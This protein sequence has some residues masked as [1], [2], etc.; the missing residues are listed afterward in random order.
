M[1]P[2]PASLKGA[3]ISTCPIAVERKCACR[4][5]DEPLASEFEVKEMMLGFRKTFLYSECPG[6]GCL[7]LLDPPGDMGAY[8][9]NNYYAFS[10]PTK[11]SR[12][13]MQ[14]AKTSLRHF[15]L[16]S[17]IPGVFAFMERHG[18]VTQAERWLNLGRARR[19][20]RILDIGCGSG[21]LLRELQADGYRNLTGIDPFSPSA[22]HIPGLRLIKGELEAL[23]GEAFDLV[24]MHHSLEHVPDQ[25][26]MLSA[27]RS[28]LTPKGLLLVRIPIKATAFEIYGADWVQID[29]P[30]H[31]L[32]HS[33]RSLALAA[34]RA[35][36]RLVSKVYDSWSFQFWG[37]EQYRLGIHLEDPRSVGKGGNAFSP[38]AI[39]EYNRRAGVLNT[40]QKGD[41]GIFVFEASANRQR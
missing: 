38:S 13:W 16:Y 27:A 12:S 20:S 19:S 9:P 39:E 25:V 10:Q 34:S 29:A 35:G 33:E 22:G 31:F 21:H 18:R 2:H 14:Q 40:E 11:P 6:C 30:R 8:Y 28:L 17:G 5:C 26:A 15:I 3:S 7:T 24:M 23:K 4:I 32:I 37:S 41:Q 1:T 36:L